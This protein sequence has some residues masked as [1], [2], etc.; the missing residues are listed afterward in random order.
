[1][2]FEIEQLAQSNAVDAAGNVAV[3]AGLPAFLGWEGALFSHFLVY[4]LVAGACLTLAA[5]LLQ[6]AFASARPAEF[7][8]HWTV[9]TL[10]VGIAGGIAFELARLAH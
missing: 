5:R 4:A 6:P 8:V 3:S 1:M 9:Q 2:R 7:A 10:V